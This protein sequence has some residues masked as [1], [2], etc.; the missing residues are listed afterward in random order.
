MLGICVNYGQ[1]LR[2]TLLR[3]CGSGAFGFFVCCFKLVPIKI[4][5]GHGFF[6]IA[7]GSGG[8]RCYK[9]CGGRKLG[10]DG[11]YLLVGLYLGKDIVKACFAVRFRFKHI[12][13]AENIVLF[14]VLLLGRRGG[15]EN[16]LLGK[17]FLCG[18]LSLA[19]VILVKRN[20]GD[21]V[22]KI[23][24]GVH[25]KVIKRAVFAFIGKLRV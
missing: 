21:I 8:G 24:L 13:H 18:R 1:L 3:L 22:I 16:R 5:I 11:S 17:L 4:I 7:F 9:L 23:I 15:I 25:P 19:A 14:G 2:L 6:I 20:N 12:N 10:I